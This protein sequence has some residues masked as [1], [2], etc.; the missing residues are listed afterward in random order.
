MRI[1]GALTPRASGWASQPGVLPWPSGAAVARR[2]RPS[3]ER[4]QQVE[5]EREEDGRVLVHPD[6]EQ[7][8]EVAELE[9]RR[10]PADDVRGVRELLCRLELAVG[11]DDLRP[12]LALGLGLT[13]DSA[14]HLRR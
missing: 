1:S 9:R 10:V 3:G 7:R 14:L 6:L 11:V 2:P 4:L 5:R 8:L 12:P 13:S